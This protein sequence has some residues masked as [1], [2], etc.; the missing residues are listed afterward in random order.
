MPTKTITKRVAEWER[1]F[2]EAAKRK[3]QKSLVKKVGYGKQG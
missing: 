2:E 3:K 1:K